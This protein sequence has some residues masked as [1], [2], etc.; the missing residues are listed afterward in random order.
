MPTTHNLHVTWLLFSASV[1][2]SQGGPKLGDN[3]WDAFFFGLSPRSPTTT[4]PP[5]C[6]SPHPPTTHHHHLPDV[7]GHQTKN[8]KRVRG[9]SRETHVHHLFDPKINKPN[10][11]IF[12]RFHWCDFKRLLTLSKAVIFLFRQG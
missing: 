1:P 9:S 2:A 8:K 7:G 6:P 3:V 10:H 4:W 12:F 5:F 11:L